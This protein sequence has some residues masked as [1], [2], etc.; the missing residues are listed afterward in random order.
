MRIGGYGKGFGSFDKKDSEAR[1]RSFRKRHRV[2]EELRGVVLRPAGQGLAWVRV[3]GHELLAVLET[4]SEPGQLLYFRV[5]QLTPE[6]VLQEL[7]V[8]PPEQADLPDLLRMGFISRSRLE[9]ASLSLDSGETGESGETDQGTPSERKAA[10]L[11]RLEESAELRGLYAGLSE[12]EELIN[13]RLANR[14]GQGTARFSFTPWLVPLAR[15]QEALHVQHPAEE[16]GQGISDYLFG[17]TLPGL[18]RCHVRV[19]EQP[20]LARF[21]LILEK[22]GHAEEVEP[23]VARFLLPE[24]TG[25]LEQLGT[26]LLRPGAE[27]VLS[28]YLEPQA[29]RLFTGLNKRV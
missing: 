26:K 6:I 24:F 12:L 13:I 7:R 1:K 28:A 19:L 2:G 10:F 29:Q 15:D 4:A 14:H 16:Q 25:R 18:G 23:L 11:Q 27:S 20:P 21:R 5:N 22:P 9:S 3:D 8:V 17:F